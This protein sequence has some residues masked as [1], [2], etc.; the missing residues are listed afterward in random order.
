MTIN[1]RRRALAIGKPLSKARRAAESSFNRVR[2]GA[3]PE[4]PLP[5][6]LLSADKSKLPQSARG[7]LRSGFRPAAAVG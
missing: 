5:L 7:L 1:L 2:G 4:P 6:R 3:G